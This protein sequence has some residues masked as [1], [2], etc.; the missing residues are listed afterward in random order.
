MSLAQKAKGSA[1]KLT[2]KQTDAEFVTELNDQ[3]SGKI[4]IYTP[5]QFATLLR[6]LDER[7]VPFVALGGFAGLR[8]MEILQLEWESCTL[9]RP[10]P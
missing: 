1:A 6:Y 2:H 8:T 10:S 9:S 7:F 5:K 3:K 4:G